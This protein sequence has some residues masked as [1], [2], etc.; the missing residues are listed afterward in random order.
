MYKPDRWTIV[1]IYDKSE[2]FIYKVVA[3][4]SGGYL[5]GDSWRVNSGI[6]EIKVEG[7][8]VLF[9]GASGSVYKCHKETYGTNMLSGG[10]LAKMKE[11]AKVNNIKLE[12]L[13]SET[14]WITL[15]DKKGQV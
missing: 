15:L 11:M 2:A 6:V 7:D 1:K 5:Q 10:V 13:S 8:D 9:I 12:V 4:W 14:D 3:G